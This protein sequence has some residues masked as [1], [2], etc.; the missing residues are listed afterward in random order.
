MVDV[1]KVWI[2]VSFGFSGPDVESIIGS[3][4][5]VLIGVP[6]IVKALDGIISSNQI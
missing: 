5:L 6:N 4:Q 1:P 2:I 3:E